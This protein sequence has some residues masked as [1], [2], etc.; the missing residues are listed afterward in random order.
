V[1]KY[2]NINRDSC[3]CKKKKHHIINK[4]NKKFKERNPNMTQQQGP[5]ARRLGVPQTK[6][7][8]GMFYGEPKL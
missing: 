1:Q 5:A 3:F 7:E 2:C 4:I 8:Q 6:K